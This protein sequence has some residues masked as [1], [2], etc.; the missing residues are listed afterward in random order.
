MCFPPPPPF[1]H[2]NSSPVS[3]FYFPLERGGGGGGGGEFPI[4]PLTCVNRAGRKE[5]DE[6]GDAY[7]SAHDDGDNCHTFW[8]L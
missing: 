6:N 4:L 7:V 8:G 3:V 2:W 5:R 1:T